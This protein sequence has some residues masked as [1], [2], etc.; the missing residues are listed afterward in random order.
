MAITISNLT[1]A[2]STT[3]A[4][5][6][7]ITGVTAAI[8]DLLIVVVAADNNGTS[9]ALSMTSSMTDSGGANTYTNRML[10]LNDPGA[11]AAGASLGVWTCPVTSALSAATITA[12]FSPAT[13]A[14]CAVV[15][16]VTG[17]LYSAIGTAVTP[18]NITAHSANAV[19]V[20]SGDCI[21][22]VWG[23]ETNAAPTWDSDT[24]NGSWSTAYTAVANAGTATT[25]MY[26]GAQ[27][28]TVN[29]TGS[30]TFNV[31][32]AANSDGVIN[33]LILTPYDKTP[34]VGG[35]TVTG[36]QPTLT[37]NYGVPPAVGAATTTGYAPA[38]NVAYSVTPG[39]GALTA[40]GYTP[41][42]SLPADTVGV[43]ALTGYAPTLSYGTLQV[44]PT[45][46]AGSVIPATSYRAVVDYTGLPPYAPSFA[47]DSAVPTVSY[48]AALSRIIFTPQANLAFTGYAV[49]A[50][51]AIKSTDGQSV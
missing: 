36:Q 41:T 24:T 40:T 10:G 29:A 7:A 39:V 14:K 37:Y 31:T 51:N 3:S 15:Y 42:A 20:T 23:T 34:A 38:L 44:G 2:N 21:V 6:L 4:T 13:T 35:I 33:Y 16:K 28:K 18:V 27:Y 48:T 26:V 32:A 46:N 47:A 30:Q 49:A 22:G 5:T 25:S 19:S 9:G 45:W 8:G 12:N 11:A 43:V 17:A 1:T 50:G